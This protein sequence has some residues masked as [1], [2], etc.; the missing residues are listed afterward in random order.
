MCMGDLHI[1]FLASYVM[2]GKRKVNNIKFTEGS[3]YSYSKY[4]NC[5]EQTHLL[6]NLWSEQDP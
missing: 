4:E 3:D 5:S 1:F 2:E 6:D